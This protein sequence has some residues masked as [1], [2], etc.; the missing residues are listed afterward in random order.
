MY[1]YRLIIQCNRF[2]I[3]YTRP[4]INGMLSVYEYHLTVAKVP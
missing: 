3:E 2:T 1:M 4:S